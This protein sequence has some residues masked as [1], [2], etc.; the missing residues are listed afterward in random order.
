VDVLTVQGSQGASVSDYEL[1]VDAEGRAFTTIDGH[2]VDVVE[3]AE[4]EHCHFVMCGPASFFPDDVHTLCAFCGAGIVHRPYV[5][6]K[7]PKICIA[8][9]QS[10]AKGEQ[11]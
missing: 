11:S 9:A 10:I 4:A 1:Q 3:D 5:P 2:R 6:A 7:P 8:C